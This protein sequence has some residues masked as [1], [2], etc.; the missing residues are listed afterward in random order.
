[1]D[2]VCVQW[3]PANVLQD[4]V[5]HLPDSWANRSRTV[6]STRS[7]LWDVVCMAHALKVNAFANKVGKGQTAKIHNARIIVLVTVSAF[8][9]RCTVLASVPVTMAGLA[10]VASALQ[11]TLSS[12]H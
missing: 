7:A 9:S 4:G 6:A 1:M 3:G 5:W 10:L 8:S 11:S 12:R 2:M